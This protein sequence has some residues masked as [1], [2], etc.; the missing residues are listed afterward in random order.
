MTFY[1][2]VFKNFYGQFD[3]Y[4]D[5]TNNFFFYFALFDHSFEF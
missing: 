1:R 4:N 5:G 3:I 2:M